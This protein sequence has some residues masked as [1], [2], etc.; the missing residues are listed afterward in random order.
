M[1]SVQ[2]GAAVAKSIFVD[3]G[4]AGVVLLRLVFGS[5]VL[6]VLGRPRLRDLARGQLQL[7]LAF[8]TTLACMNLSF[9]SAID[10]VPLGIVVTLRFVGPLVVAI[11]GSR[12]RLDL[13]WAVSAATGVALLAGGGAGA[14]RPLGV[15]LAFIAGACWAVYILLSARV[16]RVFPG[17]SG[18]A[19]AMVIG[20]TLVAPIGIATGG[21]GLVS[22]HTLG[23]GAAIG[24][25]S[26]ALPWSL[27][28]EALRRIPTHV[29]GV[30]MSLEPAIAAVAGF[31]LL[32][33]RLHAAAVVALALVVAA[34]AGAAWANRGPPA[35]DPWGSASSRRNAVL[36]LS[37]RLCASRER[38]R[39]S[40]G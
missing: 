37:L 34:C 33:Q 15:V 25:L 31:M 20:A 27:E 22:I 2:I 5:S 40:G 21:D 14:L 28:L 38:D 13:V 8:G 11:F 4:P 9:Y 19:V 23:L 17:A 26:S 3:V 1:V 39:K 29:F 16:G 6:I 18:L 30:L 35:R 7:A 12:R 24:V 32:G 36:A 10:R